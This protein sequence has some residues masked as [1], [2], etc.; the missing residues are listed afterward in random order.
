M[1]VPKYTCTILPFSQ[2]IFSYAVLSRSLQEPLGVSGSLVQESHEVSRNLQETLGISS[3]SW[4]RVFLG[5]Q[6]QLWSIVIRVC[7]VQKCIRQDIDQTWTLKSFWW[8]VGGQMFQLTILNFFFR[9]TILNIIYEL[10][11]H[12]GS[13]I[14]Q[15]LMVGGS[16][17]VLLPV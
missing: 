5:L 10:C 11:Q 3:R 1:H 9:K 6:C 8:W 16:L 13:L 17:S 14:D 2:C 7:N 4:C 12:Q 15:T